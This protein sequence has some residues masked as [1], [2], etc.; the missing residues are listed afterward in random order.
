M[1]RSVT[2]GAIATAMLAT[3]AA[4]AAAQ[5]YPGYGYGQPGYGY[6]YDRYRQRDN[7]GAVIAGVAVIGVIAA[8]AAAS[9][10]RRN[11]G[12]YNG[13]NGNIRNENEAAQACADAAQGQLGGRV[14]G[15]DQVYRTREG[16]AVRGSVERGG[17]GYGYGGGYGNGY[18]RGSN[19]QGFTCEVRYGR[20]ASINLGRYGY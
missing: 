5:R 20:V 10:N 19:A 2:V 11:S 17:N 12:R 7:T 1:L 3:S 9:A 15:I 13:Y 16:F 14:S 18:G 8:I 6:D 4:P